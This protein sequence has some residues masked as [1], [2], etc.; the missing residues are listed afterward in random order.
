MSTNAEQLMK[1]GLECAEIFSG[2]YRFLQSHPKRCI[3]YPRNLWGY[4]TDFFE[5]CIECRQYIVIK[6]F[7]S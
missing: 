6:H 2:I 3:C 1:L 7:E 5:T 4:W